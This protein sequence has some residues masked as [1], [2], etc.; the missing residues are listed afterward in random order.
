MHLVTVGPH[1]RRSRMLFR[2]ALGKDYSIGVTCLEESSYDA[3][4]WYTCSDGVRSVMGEF[5][6]YVYARL[7]FHP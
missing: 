7:F 2:K 3:D 1:G 4:D 6:A 5:I